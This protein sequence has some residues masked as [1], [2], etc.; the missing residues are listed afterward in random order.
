MVKS[1]IKKY[2]LIAIF[3]VFLVLEIALMI[4]LFSFFS[5]PVSGGSGGNVTVITTLTVGNVAPEVLTIVLT[6][7]SNSSTSVNV[8]LNPASYKYA[9]CNGVVRDWNNNTDILNVTARLFQNGTSEF[10]SDDNNIHYTNNTCYIDYNVTNTIYGD[11]STGNFTANYSCSFSM[12]YYTSPGIWN[13]SVYAYDSYNWNGTNSTTGEVNELLAVTLPSSIDYGTVNSTY[14]SEENITNVSNA[15]NVMINLSLQGYAVDVG[16]GYAMNCS[17]GNVKNISIVYEK[18]NLTA[19]NPS[20]S[21]LSEFESLYRNLT[22]SAVVKKFNL[23][24]RQEDGYDDAIN[25]TYWRIYVPKGVAGT[26]QGNII[27]GATKADGSE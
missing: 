19:S 21:G 15:G 10:A 23:N 9:Y 3:S 16:D 6:N 22:S 17:K 1:L 24:Y 7:S 8:T 26:C 5:S 25:A 2:K 20:V 12:Q 27:F 18:Y 11:D 14:V 4:F 13:C